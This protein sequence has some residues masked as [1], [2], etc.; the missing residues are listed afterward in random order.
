MITLQHSNGEQYEGE[1]VREDQH[2]IWIKIS[3]GKILCI[4]RTD[5]KE[6]K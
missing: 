4:W 3:T 2:R 6:T 5:I 1:L